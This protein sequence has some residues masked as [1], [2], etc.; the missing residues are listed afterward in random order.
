MSQGLFTAATGIAANQALLDVIS[1][2]IAN[3]NTVGFKASQMNFETVFSK[4]LATGSAPT[5][6]V[7]GINPKEIGLGVAVGE[8]GKNFSNGSIQTTGR[9]TDLN[10]QGEGFFTMMNYDGKQFLSRAGNFSTDSNGHLV[11]PQ[12]L[13]VIGTANSV[14]SVSSGTPVQI[15]TKLKIIVPDST[16][17]SLVSNIGQDGGQTISNG[18]FSINVSNGTNNDDVIVTL[19]DGDT[20]ADIVTKMQAAILSS[21]YDDG[22]TT[23]ALS[24]NKI[25]V[26]CTGDTLT[27][28]GQSSDTSNFLSVAGMGAGTVPVDYTSAEF[29]DNSQITIDAPDS[30]DETY[31]VTNFSISNDG[32]IEAT[33]ANGS[34]VTVSTNSSTGNK[35]LK[36]VSGSGRVIQSSNITVQNSAVAPQQLQLQLA[37]VIN[38]KGLESVGGNLFA[39]N[40]IAGTPTYATGRSGGLGVINSGS[41]EASNVDMPT[42]F[43]NMILAQRGVEANSRTFEVQNT[44][45]RTIVN[46]GR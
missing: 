25:N 32:A 37:T 5:N 20:L 19:A 16:G 30:S 23:V 29:V 39:L 38:P 36:Y 22:N 8:I 34:R 11:N 27:F 13:K 44:I 10:I 18:T 28:N 40:S 26:T 21:A 17:A 15:P 43:A 7:G 45:M 9:S 14:S 41:L 35:E 6:D 2:N 4:Q 1:D 46:L 33:Y 42:E 3:I 24:G 31:A 12:G